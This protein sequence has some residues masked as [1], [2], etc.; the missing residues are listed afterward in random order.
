MCQVLSSRLV[1]PSPLSSCPVRTSG[2]VLA[3][4]AGTGLLWTGPHGSE[5]TWTITVPAFQEPTLGWRVG[6]CVWGRNNKQVNR[7]I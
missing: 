2:L 6:V 5:V 1:W 7:E 3:K 4:Q